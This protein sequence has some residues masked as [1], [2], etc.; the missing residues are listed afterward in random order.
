MNESNNG[1][2]PPSGNGE[3]PA[4]R[5]FL[6]ILGLLISI[7]AVFVALRPT[8][9]HQLIG[10]EAESPDGMRMQ[11]WFAAAFLVIAVGLR[12]AI[13]QGETALASFSPAKA[14]A[15][16]EK[17]VRGARSLALLVALKDQPFRTARVASLLLLTLSISVAVLYMGPGIQSAILHFFPTVDVRDAAGIAYVAA[18][19]LSS[20]LML[21]IGEIVPR[22]VGAAN[23]E[24]S[25]LRRSWLL[26]AT[27]SI[28]HAPTAITVW[29]AG[30]LCALIRVRPYTPV[31][32]VTEEQLRSL[33]E[34]SEEQ[35]ELEEEEREMLHSVF[36]FTD[37]T[38]REVMTPRTDMD[39]VSVDAQP[40]EIV[41][42]IDESGHSRI[43]LHR[44]TVD[45]IVGVVHAKDLLRYLHAGT[46]FRL[47]DIMRPVYLIPENK[48]LGELMSEFRTGRN[49]L[50]IVRDEY[51]GTAGLVTIEDVVEE[52]VGE[53]VDEYDEE[54]PMWVVQPDGG[55]LFDGRAHLDDVNELLDT[56]L[57][58]AEFDTIGGY[59]FGLIGHQPEQGETLAA[60]GFQFEITQ[61]DGR[62]IQKVAIHKAESQEPAAE[63]L[64]E[65]TAQ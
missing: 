28:L 18:F 49:Q 43:P 10:L 48:K 53:I 36:D 5:W 52:I 39:T 20:T 46:G 25:A 23:V 7:V 51:G 34:A 37:T 22:S 54:E 11:F 50:A 38:V 56:E 4:P 14:N 8:W 42:L 55:F 60:D 62:R 32:V 63:A 29:L 33:L 12:F 35:G 47:E 24:R 3:Q 41:K 1:E 13:E 59:V 26:L 31:P 19:L 21:V 61:T 15:L 45:H 30:R 64:H 65:E 17:K 6:S 57:Q 40:E 16:A 58:S 9:L 27:N 2:K 44:E